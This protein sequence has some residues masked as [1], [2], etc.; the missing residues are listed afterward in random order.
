MNKIKDNPMN[1]DFS[2]KVIATDFPK[3][4]ISGRIVSWNEAGVTSAGETV[5]TP[6]SITFGDNTKLL[7]EHNRTSPIGFLKS[8]SVNNQGVDAVFSVLPTNAGNDSLIEASSGARDGFSVGVTADKY[9]LIKGVLTITASTLREVSLVT[10]PAIASAKVSVAANLEDNS[11]PLI[12]EESDKPTTTKPEGDEVETTPTVPEASA[13]TVEAASQNVQASTR[14]V[15]FTKPRSPINSD[16]SYLEHTIRATFNPNSDSALWVRAADDTMTTVGGFNPTRQLNEVINGLT[17]YTRSNI[18]AISRGTLPDAGMTFEIPK[19]T[20]IP[21]VAAT[22]EEGT[23]SET[24]AT[25]SYLSCTVAKYAGQNTLSV[26]LIDRSSPAF[27]EELLRL[28]AGAYAVATDKAV[29]AAII[30]GAT[31]DGTSIA[32]Y[33]TASELLGFVSRGAASV[34]AGTQGFARNIIANTSQWSNLMTLN[35]SGAPLYNVAAGQTNTTGGV[36]TPT[37]IRGVVA[38]LDL[39][40]TANTAS[41]TDT[42][43]SM[44]IV[45][46]D[47]YTWYESPTLRLT[48][49]LIG[50]GQVEVMYYGYG[51]IATKVGAGAFKIN[52]T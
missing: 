7:L 12:Q 47:S 51:A 24:G 48:S 31:A 26:E 27:F 30:S 3:R 10:D 39:Y 34:Y 1:I 15:F 33:P 2:I 4:E 14:P 36:A 46:P 5:F 32:T 44:L 22:A 18:D 35:V 50:T 13:E 38:G 40:V 8:Y 6:G 23:P 52:K 43:G 41:L 20:A 9:E 45:N 42:D 29:N 21:T 37:S 19:I 49:N 17:N 16:A 11:V 28:M 25:A